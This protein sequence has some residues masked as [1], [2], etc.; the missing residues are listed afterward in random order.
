MKHNF[1]PRRAALLGALG[2]AGAQGAAAQQAG[3]CLAQP[4]AAP[5]QRLRETNERRARGQRLRRGG[6]G[7]RLRALRVSPR[8]A[9]NLNYLR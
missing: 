2:L 4:A 7:G 9:K 3:R 1:L 6:G 5:Q 8:S